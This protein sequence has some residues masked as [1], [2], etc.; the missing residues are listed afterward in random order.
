MRLKHLQGAV[1]A[2]CLACAAALAAF[3][4]GAEAPPGSEGPNYY[5]IDRDGFPDNEDRC[6][7]EAAPESNDGCPPEPEVIVVVGTG[8]VVCPDGRE[9]SDVRLC[10]RYFMWS[11]YYAPA[12]WNRDTGIVEGDNR[13][14]CGS[15]VD[16]QCACG[17]GKVKV[18]DDSNETFHCKTE[19]PAAGCSWDQDFDF[20]LNVWACVTR[21]FDNSNA[22]SDAERIKNC[23]GGVVAR[24]WTAISQV[25]YAA[26]PGAWGDVNCASPPYNVRLNSQRFLSAAS[27]T[28]NSPWQYA[29]HT[30]IHEAIH[31]DD[32]RTHGGGCNV[33]KQPKLAADI[34]AAGHPASLAGY[35]AYTHE[36]TLREY[37]TQLGVLSPRE[38]RPNKQYDPS[39][40]RNIPCSV[41]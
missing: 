41:Q 18:Y 35:E 25:T 34:S 6:P 9:V 32:M 3:Q 29:T 22:K 24:N 10:P 21:P 26:I 1:C 30:N 20:D 36:R 23:V 16:S 17:A 28:G 33:Y 27:S 19:P 39:K 13:Q 12:T 8:F 38:N 7:D 40:H 2:V 37:E 11:T 4:A 15:T 31:V 5:D 14:P